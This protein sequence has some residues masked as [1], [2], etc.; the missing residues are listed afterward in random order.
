M[1]HPALEIEDLRKRYVLGEG[2]HDY[3][4]LRERLSP[5]RR[6]RPGR[7]RA[8]VW[9][10]NSVSFTVDE[11][12]TVGLIGANGAGK[13]TLLKI[14]ARITRP[15]AG[16]ARMWGTVGALLEVGTGF[17]PELTGHE[18]IYLNGAIL[19]MSRRDVARR[20][21]DIVAFAGI[22]RFLHTPLK[23]Y[24]S[25]MHLRLAFAV[26]AHLEPDIVVVDEVLAVGDFE[27]QQRCLG[28]MSEVEREGRTA[29]FVSHDL[30]A[31]AQL[32]RRTIWLEHGRI[33]AD[34]PTSE[35]VERYMDS[36]L[37]S[38][39]Q[40]NALPETDKAVQLRSVSL[41]D[42]AG[43]PLQRPRR[44]LPFAL[45]LEFVVRE[46]TAGLDM[47]VYF[48]NEAG[49]RV[50]DDSMSQ[51]RVGGGGTYEPGQYEALA[52]IP[53]VLAA[54]D[55][56]AGVYIGA[57]IETFFYREVLGFTLFPRPGDRPGSS[58]VVHP[59]VE[60]RVSRRD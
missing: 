58:R 45:R 5:L 51:W 14:I 26:A 23:R 55:Y 54:G 22:E 6:I 42:E 52:V 20:Y 13:T 12:E 7:P 49:L 44:D 8:D 36:Y 31:V 1:A 38:S 17:H 29:L 39:A 56:L 34:G 28:R 60:W 46:R 48:H 3:A 59:P 4:T 33:E 41:A 24:S 53:P 16:V 15:T 57:G 37:R 47:S 18:N 40:L 21:D 9:A 2:I 35:I 10:L 43:A 11:G 27:F 50:L 32:C 19:G 25:G 30:G